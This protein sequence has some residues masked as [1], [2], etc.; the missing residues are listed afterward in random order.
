MRRTL[1]AA[2]ALGA[3][4]LLSLAFIGCGPPKDNDSGNTTDNS[5]GTTNQGPGP[6]AKLTAL[7]GKE[8]AVL[9]GRVTLKGSKPDTAV[10][11]TQMQDLM[12][13]K[14]TPTCFDMA[15]EAEKTQQ[16]WILG[17]AGDGKVGVGNVV[18]WIQPPDGSFFRVSPDENGKWWDK[19]IGINQPHCAF[20]PHV[21]WAVPNVA[22]NADEPKKLVPSG[23]TFT[24]SNT[25]NVSHNTKWSNEGGGPNSGTLPPLEPN[26]P[27]RPVTFKG[28][29]QLVHFQCDIHP[30]MDAYV[31]VFSH[32]YAA[33]TKS[34]PKDPSSI[35]TYEI[36]NVPAGSKVRITAWHEQGP[37]QGFLTSA[38]IKG[39]EIEL[40]DGETTKDFELE[41][42]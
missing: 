18:V 41:A 22:A 25:A 19:E 29:N 11:T 17:D 14:D 34:D 26:K 37:Y 39:D 33:V 35:G 32:P 2:A 27:P 8:G 15:P 4:L 30:W 1:L 36:K 23:Q 6:A 31:W 38:K 7:P 9:K 16:K 40:K 24:V 3:P 20:I 13:K 28:N 21:S 10:L 42:K 12:K 5:G